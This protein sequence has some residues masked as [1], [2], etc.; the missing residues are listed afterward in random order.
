M[1]YDI[2]SDSPVREGE[3]VADKYLVDRV[4]GVGGNGVVVAARHLAL[5]RPVALKFLLKAALARPE[6]VERFAREARAAAKVESRHVAQVLDVAS[7]PDGTPYMVMEYLEGEDL[8]QLLKRCGPSPYSV[9]VSYILQACE[10]VA[11]AH[12]LGI[13]HRDIKPGNLFVARGADAI[14]LIKVLDF[15]IS[16]LPDSVSAL[17][18][19]MELVGSPFVHVAGTNPVGHI[20]RRSDRHLGARRGP[21]PHAHRRATVP[22]SVDPDDHSSRDQRRA[23]S[24]ADSSPRRST[25]PRGGRPQVSDEGSRG[26][27]FEPRRP[28]AGARALRPR[29]SGGL[30]R[31]HLAGAQQARPAVV[32]RDGDARW[33]HGL[34]RRLRQASHEDRASCGCPDAAAARATAGKELG[35]VS[36]PGGCGDRGPAVG[37]GGSAAVCAPVPLECVIIAVAAASGPAC[38]EAGGHAREPPVASRT[39]AIAP[40]ATPRTP[41]PRGRGAAH[42]LTHPRA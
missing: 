2:R 19:P 37:R 38:A 23:R 35:A 30:P 25:G 15:G 4:L 16:K 42:L 40:R 29:A 36:G 12:A 41:C 9:A 5:D 34:E 21:L 24:R 32:T 28:C 33:L 11:E 13:I 14:P 18:Q 3:M 1:A 22:G 31:R 20:G 8:R 26:A 7:L 39:T 17:T 10:G 27:V 6:I